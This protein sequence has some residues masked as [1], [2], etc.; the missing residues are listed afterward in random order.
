MRAIL[1]LATAFLLS[2]SA[3]LVAQSQ[4][5][6][7]DEFITDK[8]MSGEEKPDYSNIKNRNDENTS[9]GEKKKRNESEVLNVQD[10]KDGS[11][12][13][14]PK[15]IEGG[16]VSPEEV[17]GF[18][19]PSKAEDL[20]DL[21]KMKQLEQKPLEDYDEELFLLDG[22]IWLRS[23]GEYKF[24]LGDKITNISS[25]QN[26]NQRT[27]G[28]LAKTV[29]YKIVLDLRANKH[30]EYVISLGVYISPME[31][32]G[33]FWAI[34]PKIIISDISSRGIGYAMYPDYPNEGGTTIDMPDIKP[35]RDGLIL[36]TQDIIFS[37]NFEGS[38]P[39]DNG[40][41]VGDADP[42]SGEDYWDDVNCF[43]HWGS[44]SAWCADIGDMPNCEYYD[45]NMWAYMIS[46]GIEVG[47]YENVELSYYIWY[48]T[49]PNYDYFRRFYSSNGEDWTESSHVYDGNSGGWRHK[50]AGLNNFNTY[51]V[52]F[53]FDS[54]PSLHIN[55]EGVY[56]D[57]IEITGDPTSPDYAEIWGAWWTNEVDEDGD[58]YVS[59]ARLVWDPDVVGCDG[60]LSVYE[61]IYWR[62]PCGGG[63]WNFLTETDP[64]TINDCDGSDQQYINITGGSHNTYDWQIRLYREGES[65]PD[66]TYDDSDDSDLSCYQME[67]PGEVSLRKRRQHNPH[68]RQD[69]H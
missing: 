7:G 51:Y 53:V 34:V 25:R 43:D 5:N 30:R 31:K 2:L 24:R 36:D 67:T 14:P 13:N 16:Q 29:E 18:P 69:L 3:I 26:E 21:E 50:T 20:S 11:I 47:G 28:K 45:D 27:K 49:E 68:I 8:V 40:W 66:D 17:R 65:S 39:G 60:T 64:H 56:L 54:D 19:K 62:R 58:D 44:W 33:Y 46:P 32:K 52:N 1:I 63:S 57:D 37:E 22:E 12:S 41:I 23:K 10:Y 55:Y 59:S 48:D 42:G 38:F 35:Q 15:A 9:S 61:R 4:N 6:K